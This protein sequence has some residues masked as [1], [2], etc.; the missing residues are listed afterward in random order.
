MAVDLTKIL[1]TWWTAK[2]WAIS[3]DT[4]KFKD[5]IPVQK[6]SSFLDSLISKW[7]WII[8]TT[9]DLVSWWDKTKNALWD[10]IKTT[11]KIAPKVIS[12]LAIPELSKSVKQVPSEVFKIPIVWEKILKPLSESA[13][14][15]FITPQTKQ[16]Q[17]QTKQII[18]SYKP[19]ST[20]ETAKKVA[21]NYLLDVPLFDKWANRKAQEFS[22]WNKESASQEIV[23]AWWDVLWAVI[24]VISFIPST[25]AQWAMSATWADKLISD[26]IQKWKNVLYPI[27]DKIWMDR[28]DASALVDW[29]KLW[30]DTYFWLKSWIK[31]EQASA[32]L[33]WLWARQSIDRFIKTWEAW[34]KSNLTKILEKWWSKAVKI[35]TEAVYQSIP[36]LTV[37]ILWWIFWDNKDNKKLVQSLWWTL[38]AWA[39]PWIP[40]WELKWKK[41]SLD[42]IIK[43]T[44]TVKKENIIAEA[45]SDEKI[46]TAPVT[47]KKLSPEDMTLLQEY[48]QRPDKTKFPSFQEY[49]DSLQKS[50]T[51]V[52]ETPKETVPVA[53]IKEVAPVKEKIPV[54]KS[55][56]P[57]V[58]SLKETV[59]VEN[60]KQPVIKETIKDYWYNLENRPVIIKEVKWKYPILQW[61][62]RFSKW[63]WNIDA[64]I[65]KWTALPEWFTIVKDNIP[66]DIVSQA[67]LLSSRWEKWT[68]PKMVDFITKWID[69]WTHIQWPR[70]KLIAPLKQENIKSSIPEVKIKK[71]TIIWEKI[72]VED[73]LNTKA[74][75]KEITID[76]AP[77][78]I[79][80]QDKIIKQ[81]ASNISKDAWDEFIKTADDSKNIRI[82]SVENISKPVSSR[83]NRTFGATTFLNAIKV[84]IWDWKEIT[85][86]ALERFFETSKKKISVNLYNRNLKWF[87]DNII[88]DNKNIITKWYNDVAKNLQEILDTSAELNA[89]KPSEIA[90]KKSI[91]KEIFNWI[92]NGKDFIYNIPELWLW[93]KYKVIEQYAWL[94]HLYNLNPEYFDKN[95][96]EIS[97]LI[98]DTNASVSWIKD[99]IYKT[100][101][102]D[103]S[104]RWLLKWIWA[105]YQHDIIL[106]NVYD[107]FLKWS[108]LEFDINWKNYK[109]DSILQFRKF[110]TTNP[111][112][113]NNK[114]L[115]SILKTKK[116]LN[117]FYLKSDL[118]QLIDYV[119]EYWELVWDNNIYKF[120]KSLKSSNDPGIRAYT[121]KLWW[122]TFFE[123]TV[124]QL[125]W[126]RDMNNST[127]SKAIWYV[128][129]KAI[130]Y[131][132]V[133]L[134]LWKVSTFTQ[135]ITTWWV[136]AAI[137]SI[138]SML[139]KKI[140]WEWKSWVIPEFASNLK[141]KILSPIET[142]NNY[143]AATPILEKYG[144]LEWKAYWPKADNASLL[145]KW[146]SISVWTPLDNLY[147][148]QTSLLLMKEHLKNKWIETTWDALDIS[149]KFDNLM[150]K[151][152]TAEQ[153]VTENDIKDV[154]EVFSNFS[155]D[156]QSWL[157]LISW[158]KWQSSLKWFG[159]SQ[160]GTNIK[161]INNLI[162]WVYSH[163]SKNDTYW[164]NKAG[165]AWKIVAAQVWAYYAA[166]LVWQ[167]IFK[168]VSQ[169][170]Q[171][172]QDELAKKFANIAI[173]NPLEIAMN[174]TIWLA[175]NILFVPI[176][177]FKTAVSWLVSFIRTESPESY[178]P[179]LDKLLQWFAIYQTADTIAQW[180]LDEWV[181]SILWIRD[182]N[183]PV[184]SWWS[185]KWVN[186]WQWLSEQAKRIL[187][188]LFFDIDSTVANSI[189]NQIA[190][191]EKQAKDA[192][193]KW[194]EFVPKDNI[195][196]L[197]SILVPSIDDLDMKTWFIIRDY[198]DFF[199]WQDVDKQLTWEWL[200]W[201][202]KYI[203]YSKNIINNQSRATSYNILKSLDDF[204]KTWN[205]LTYDE[206]A[207]IIWLED[208]SLLDK[209]NQN[210]LKNIESVNKSIKNSI[211]ELYPEY[212]TAYNWDINAMLDDMKIKNPVAYNNFIWWIVRTK[213]ALDNWQ[214]D[215]KDIVWKQSLAN[216]FNKQTS[217]NII[218]A[219]ISVYNK[220]KPQSTAIAEQIRQV[221]VDMPKWDTKQINERLWLL[222][223]ISKLVIKD[224]AFTTNASDSIAQMV[225]SLTEWDLKKLYD[226]DLQTR[227]TLMDNYPTLKELLIYSLSMRWDKVPSDSFNLINKFVWKE[228]NIKVPTTQNNIPTSNIPTITIPSWQTKTNLYT[229]AL[230][231]IT[232][233]QPSKK[234]KTKT[235][236]LTQ[237]L[238][239]DKTQKKQQLFKTS[240]QTDIT[241]KLSTLDKIIGLRK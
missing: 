99:I 58:T 13:I 43:D 183:T 114:S 84:K 129:D 75:P 233:A 10:I 156:W 29:V 150:Q 77:F 116:W 19:T 109:F 26:T 190:D 192:Q 51:P 200:P 78:D 65:P 234:T 144:F 105:D 59:P 103:L 4:S 102:V 140:N 48:N 167:L 238:W 40:W 57:E 208:S 189:N 145:E 28:R 214:F 215:S 135:A 46:Q 182:S 22:S 225:S 14:S 212:L 92:I 220:T 111:D 148:Y 5:A 227:S 18:Q 161:S 240:W 235:K 54:V 12:W 6:Q 38:L 169:N 184:T 236:S 88:K 117:D 174:A 122:S 97:K 63:T 194:E 49:K 86:N 56:I 85:W 154:L 170:N 25:L 32:S 239:F 196:S 53:P 67:N 81:E 164:L 179:E 177:D 90:Y 74:E 226:S 69:E 100:A 207:K 217:K 20:L 44:E 55:S 121:D 96:P 151:S 45:K 219:S 187:K 24:K 172:I 191:Y 120:I 218:D 39:I 230:D 142:I 166:F 76:D 126:I 91:A 173:W 79:P 201:F 197:I 118:Y 168:N 139:P 131:A 228:E 188:T 229:S 204:K 205:P 9:T 87:V 149:T 83:I 222:E 223:A 125:A 198:K 160:T 31:W 133:K 23:N 112:L 124:K 21:A 193:Q 216:E 241:Q 108:P 146:L 178:T 11:T 231:K 2:I 143:E 153:I 152:S 199:W 203:W 158:I 93:W 162:D 210:S 137:L 80:E 101:W 130:K 27:T 16:E 123:D 181:K 202:L 66:K 34:V 186:A 171:E 1:K 138:P 159:I 7:K 62:W 60:I 237:L 155:T 141:Q 70:E 72:P 47:T 104:N 37:G 52:I 206:L 35:W 147:K 42:S 15:S 113:F 17:S 50:T 213:I 64:F 110:M 132:K 36:D 185:I 157:K 8:K 221:L 136:K 224:E 98:N 180:K 119:N 127:T 71:E 95:Y 61:T 163:F 128:A 195:Q 3:V 175:N 211:W 209:W 165:K 33:K 176:K 30:L 106:K 89:W 68:N 107:T 82:W 134:L 115:S 232:I 41:T 94:D 73:I